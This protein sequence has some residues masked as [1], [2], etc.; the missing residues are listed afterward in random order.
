MNNLIHNW[1]HLPGHMKPYIFQIGDFQLRYYG[2][3]Y[4]VAFATVYL[5]SVYRLKR[6]D[7]PYSK[8]DVENYLMWAV[9]GLLLGA[10]LGY[11]LFYNFSYYAAYPLE[12][13]MPFSLRGGFHITGLAGMSY[14]GGLIG[15]VIAGALFCRKY[16]INIWQFS[17][18]LIPS[19]PLGY[20]FGR[21]GN[22][23]NG[24]LYG[25]ATTVPWGMYFPLDAAR[26]LRHASQLYEALLEGVLLFIILWGLRRKS[27]FDG[28]LLSLYLAGYGLV[29]FFIEFFREPDAQIGFLF[30]MVT[31]GQVLC[32]LMMLIGAAVFFVR[33]NKISHS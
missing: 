13:I 33:R 4:I 23:I 14:H 30:G 10:R 8:N 27:P 22:F 16:K 9:I 11:V 2:L 19:I 21:L 7:F 29:R 20:T 18:F 28:F 24:E 12:I 6:E 31:M 17:E 32:L 3:M 15:V 5:L 1:Q 26:Q 25:R